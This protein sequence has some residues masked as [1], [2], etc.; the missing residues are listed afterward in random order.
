MLGKLVAGALV[1]G[2]GAGLF[3]AA[4]QF[5][6]VQP[7]L[8]EAEL[9]ESGQRVHFAG[10]ANPENGADAVHD[11]ADHDHAAVSARPGITRNA[12]S[13]LFSV[14]VYTG[15]SLILIAAIAAAV[16]RGHVLTLRKGL[17]W[18]LAGFVAV[19]FAPA[20]GLPP[21]LPG[22]SAADLFSREIWWGMT[23]LA[24]AAGLW[25]VAFGSGPVGVVSA[26]ALILAPH[27][28][29]APHPVELA[30][31]PPPELAS[32]FA[33]RT[34]AVG[35]AVWAVLGLLGAQ[36]WLREDAKD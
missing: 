30:G 17:L 20:A 19:Q 22:T 9:Y 34:L 31:T 23:G 10:V 3:A 14:F 36:M 2:V 29:G 16:G 21:E 33:S 11:H 4:L 28:V 6:F 5:V 26:A 15:Y 27:L 25:I 12:M 7:L 8:L 24:T 18:G 1:A 32:L 13:V 35:M